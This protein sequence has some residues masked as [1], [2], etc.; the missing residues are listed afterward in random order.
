M[1]NAVAGWL[2]RLRRGFGRR[3][4]QHDAAGAILLDDGDLWRD[5]DG[6]FAQAIKLH[7]LQS[8]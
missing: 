5:G 8:I 1:K 2:A 4:S 3:A 6:S 7:L